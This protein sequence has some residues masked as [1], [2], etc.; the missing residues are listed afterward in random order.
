MIK[1]TTDKDRYIFLTV[2][3]FLKMGIISFKYKAKN[4]YSSFS[5]SF[6]KVPI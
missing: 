1:E 6:W 3:S 4:N 2:V 5:N